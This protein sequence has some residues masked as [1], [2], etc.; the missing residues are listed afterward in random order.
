MSQQKNP[1]RSS[2][3]N[4]RTRLVTVDGYEGSVPRVFARFGLRDQTV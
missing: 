4:H 2:G 3:T 1:C